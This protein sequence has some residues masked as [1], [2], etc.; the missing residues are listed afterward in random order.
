M[1]DDDAE[2][3]TSADIF[4][5]VLA[6]VEAE[7]RS[8]KP[9][10]RSRKPSPPA[11]DIERKLEETLSGVIPGAGKRKR[12]DPA[13]ARETARPQRRRPAPSVSEID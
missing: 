4:G 1:S 6:E 5:D 12:R 8:S 3:L 2:Q 9:G 10:S 13:P 11:R 7:A